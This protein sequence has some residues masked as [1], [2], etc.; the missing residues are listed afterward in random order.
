MPLL[1]FMQVIR[2]ISVETA[3]LACHLCHKPR[4]P[5]SGTECGSCQTLTVSQTATI[6]GC[7]GLFRDVRSN[8]FFAIFL[9]ALADNSD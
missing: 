1:L 8:R 4:N 3:R 2:V 7:L 9:K 5:T 6:K